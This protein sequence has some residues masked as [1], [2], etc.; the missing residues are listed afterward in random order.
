M[1]APKNHDDALIGALYE[2]VSAMS[3]LNMEPDPLPGLQG[4]YLSER[5][6]WAKHAVEHLHA[7][8]DLLGRACQERNILRDQI[9]R[10]ERELAAR[11]E[12]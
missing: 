12:V 2:T 9:Y 4:G 6:G 11:K 7:V 10:L 3:A 1:S 5:D 8:F